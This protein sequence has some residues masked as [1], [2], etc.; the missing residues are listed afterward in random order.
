MLFLKQRT[1]PNCLDCSQSPIFPQ[2]R[3]DRALC[4]TRASILILDVPS[5]AWARVSNLQMV[6]RTG[7]SLDS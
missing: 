3:Q 6:A 5:L 7:K 2:D 1:T 4:G